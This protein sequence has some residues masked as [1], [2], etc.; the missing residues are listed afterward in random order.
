MHGGSRRVAT[1]PRSESEMIT[2]SR[3]DLKVAYAEKNDA[4]KLGARWDPQQQTWYVPPGLPLDEFARWLPKT[5]QEPAGTQEPADTGVSLSAFLVR[6]RDVIQQGLADAHWVRLEI[7]ELRE[8]DGNL[9]LSV[10]E[11]NSAGDVL[12]TSF[13]M[14]WRSHS[15]RIIRKFK[16][17]TG[18]GLRTGIKV[19]VLVRAQFHTRHGF[20]LAVEDIDPSYTLGD[21]E[22]KLRKIRETLTHER[23]I[24]L[25]RSIPSPVDFVR[26]AVISPE[27]SAG[28][29]DFRQEADRLHG[30]GLCEFHFVRATFQG[31]AA[32]SS[33]LD[34]IETVL[35]AHRE[36]T[37]DA[38][39]IIRGGGAVTDLAWLND[40]EL[41]RRVCR[42]PIPVF[43]GI[44]HER[45]STVLDEVAH[46]RFDTP[47]KAAHHII[48]VI[49]DNGLGALAD[50][51]RIGHQ[52]RRIVS[53]HADRLA[54][55]KQRIEAQVRLGLAK[56]EAGVGRMGSEIRMGSAHQIESASQL[57]GRDDERIRLGSDRAIERAGV[58]LAG[59]RESVK[60]TSGL[61]VE[62]R[63]AAI[64][65]IVQAVSPNASR[66]IELRGP[67]STG[68]KSESFAPLAT[69]SFWRRASST[70]PLAELV[71]GP[72][73]SGGT[74]A[75]GSSSSCRGSSGW[76]LRR[77]SGEATPSCGARACGRSG[78]RGRRRQSRSWNSSS[79]TAGC[80]SRTK[81][82]RGGR[83]DERPR[84]G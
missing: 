4:K 1:T 40:L 39:V 23:I 3:V 71:A 75:R 48:Q 20:S 59:A 28:L 32:P 65:K 27:T 33:L 17:S 58:Q 72:R 26:V 62:R 44:G 43:T 77:L 37:F 82:R 54:A 66:R 25:N 80:R 22:A 34:A 41:A 70:T 69:G 29:G 38:L 73:R 67:R 19:L 83:D 46:R 31:P 9:Y 74:P 35:S 13:A 18:E 5:P 50:L 53:Q 49:R 8:K 10:E 11:R 47:S 57:L 64:D 84:T 24:Q 30:G 12:A 2:T 81:W 16:D 6:V 61:A 56:A 15:A 7:R 51:E 36:R 21:L 55:E 42:L 76:A 68:T 63:M 52:V 79:R 14:I 78:Q 60:Q 45:D